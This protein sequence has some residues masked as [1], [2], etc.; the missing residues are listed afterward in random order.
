MTRREEEDEE[1]WRYYL[2]IEEYPN[3]DLSRSEYCK[4]HNLTAQ[5]FCSLQL[6]LH[7]K[8]RTQPGVYAKLMPLGREYLNSDLTLAQFSARHNVKATD[9]SGMRTHLNYIDRIE[10]IKKRKHQEE[11]HFI[12]VP[13][14]K[15]LQVIEPEADVVEGRN[16]V[17]L[18]IQKGV[19]VIVAPEVG[20][21]KLIKIIELLKDL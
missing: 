4:K 16:C 3:Q 11:L 15:Q 8:S 12:Q 10:A 20:A 1:L 21:D 13:N 5:R 18:I 2:A 17:E 7:H 6:H 19:K 9:I 14:G